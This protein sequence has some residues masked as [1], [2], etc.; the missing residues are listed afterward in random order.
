MILRFL[1]VI[2]ALM[3]M[4]GSLVAQTPEIDDA[5]SAKDAYVLPTIS[6]PVLLE[7][8]DYDAWPGFA[9]NASAILEKGTASLFALTRVRAEIV[10]WRDRFFAALDTNAPRLSTVNNQ[11]A[12]IAP[13]EGSELTDP[14]L[15]ARMEALDAE[16]ARLSL[17]K[18][19]ANE[20]YVQAAGLVSEADIQIRQ[21]EAARLATRSQS[22]VNFSLWPDVIVAVAGS[23]TLT[24]SEIGSL[25]KSLAANG[26]YWS[27]LAVVLVSIVVVLFF[28]IRIR[29]WIASLKSRYFRTTERTAF[30][31]RFVLSLAT[32]VLPVLGVAVLS[33]ILSVSGF[34][35]VAAGQFLE[36][37]PAA[38]GLVFFAK[39]LSDWY[40]PTKEHD[41][42][43]LGYDPDTRA[44]GR[45]LVIWL[46]GVLAFQLLFLVLF[47]VKS[48]SDLVTQVAGFPFQIVSGVLLFGLGA[49][50]SHP[51]RPDTVAIFKKGHLRVLLGRLAQIIAVLG[52]LASA[53]GYAAAAQSITSPAILSLALFAF[54]VVLQQ[55][56]YA[57]TTNS[58]A[59]AQKME[60]E[61]VSVDVVE[62]VSPYGLLP[63]AINTGLFLLSLPLLAL[64][65]GA[66]TENLVDNWTR[67]RVGFSVGG[68]TISPSTFFTFGVVLVL[69]IVLTGVIKSSLKTSVLPRTGLDLGGRN[70]I[71]AGV[72][73]LGLTLSALAAFTFAGIDLSSLAIV[74]GALSLGIGFG[75]QNIVQ[76]FVAG[77]ILLIERPVSE[78]DMIEVGGQ[79]GYVRDISVRSTRIET[80]DRTDVIVPNADLISNQVINWT[81][82]NSVGRSII[83]VGVAYGSD[84]DRVV[85]ILQEAAEANPMVL[86]D[87]PPT[88]LLVAFG[89]SSL[90]FEIRAILRDVNFLMV[91]KSEVLKEIAARFKLEGIEIPFPQSDVWLRNA[92]PLTAPKEEE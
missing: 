42:G 4:S 21:R 12:A 36:A 76:N 17:P 20:A 67:F 56:S 65:W 34:T 60:G 62:D 45:Y 73:Y 1:C 49:M 10:I 90:D 55:L 39:W 83:P 68:I 7:G 63:I 6:D 66:S 44:R 48:T 2:S 47:E 88:V 50:I 85:E 16:L 91:V 72:G 58:P 81:R 92:Q 33:A 71:V 27:R 5:N 32:V 70:A 19:L 15:I 74:A 54:V 75:L 22:P 28:L 37:L 18:I 61:I 13:P 29:V 79:M 51:P 30:V 78:G 3:L 82:G 64:L 84:V 23:L 59:P 80:F 38:T 26:R 11:I 9:N 24:T 40:F 53:F 46:S 89:A 69:G 77:I 87:P 31:I 41:D 86:L 43:I 57:L 52:P 35:G 14:V 8:I 25:S